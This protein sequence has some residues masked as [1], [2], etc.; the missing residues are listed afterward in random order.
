M[1]FLTPILCSVLALPAWANAPEQSLRPDIRPGSG[2]GLVQTASATALRVSPLPTPRPGASVP[3]QDAEPE[4]PRV[5]L[6][7]AGAAVQVSLRPVKRPKPPRRSAVQTAS[8]RVVT[9]PVVTSKAG[10]V[11]GH[12]A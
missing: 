9:T 5:V 11:C 3:V 6:A 8:A 2:T 1:K 7:T 10:S 4:Q 12:R